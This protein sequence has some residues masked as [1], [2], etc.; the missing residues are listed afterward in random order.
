MEQVNTEQ[1]AAPQNHFFS[2]DV[3]SWRRQL[4][5]R[6]LRVMVIFGFLMAAGGSYFG[7]ISHTLW[8]IFAYF[9]VYFVIVLLAAWRRAPYWL[10]AVV[11]AAS[12]Y[13]IALVTFLMRGVG[14]SSRLYL[15]IMIFVAGIFGGWR[16]SVVAL[17]VSS[18][19]MVVLGWA[20]ASGHIVHYQDVV[21]T[22]AA[23]WVSLTVDLL[24][25][26]IFLMLV[27][28]YF[29]LRFAAVLT[30]RRK[31][32]WELEQQQTTLEEQVAERAADL[33]RRSAQLEAAA[34]VAREAAEIRDVEQ[35]LDMV[36]HLI[37]ARFGFYHTGIF[38]L[39]EAGE[40]A[41][42]RAVSSEG[43][44]RMLERGHRLRVG[45]TGIVG[46]VTGQGE[47]RVALDVGEDAVFF[48]NPD[49]PD[50]RSEMALPLRVRGKIIGAL[51]V[52]SVEAGEFTQEDV[53]V[54][55]TL[56]DQV[57]VAIEN[58]RL[59]TASQTALEAMQ[60][61]YGEVSRGAWQELLRA[62][63][64]LKA[65]YDPQG[66]MPPDDSWREEM[67][68]AFREGRPVFD[69]DGRLV[70]VPIKVRDQVIGILDAHKPAG[71]ED[72]SPGQIELLETL[73]DQL[74]AALE[75]ARLYQD[76]QLRAARERLAGRVAA[77]VRETLD[78]DVVLQTAVR[79]IGE[80]LGLHDV[81][82]Q[83]EDIGGE[84]GNV[85]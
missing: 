34:H 73:S 6:T 36:V 35:L 59:L 26:G 14:D 30:Q 60:R 21:S 12:L 13:T 79:E 83:F 7:Y 10:Q 66:I 76:T 64:G 8:A 33:A 25:M 16:E 69:A 58:A 71:E 5:N 45:E 4:I 55:Q 27:L 41:V 11:L 82:I 75:S 44:R 3:Q 80:A 29:M 38:L 52:Q 43:G 24:S 39:D 19:T 28:N 62:R 53:I 23:T 85:S 68:L 17:I 84:S 81:T 65:R 18:A 42:L 56:A 57:A 72:W 15:L 9:G 50:T 51:D 67:K 63:R 37:S 47:P 20:F 77:R 78:V 48:D 32:T 61:A 49:L 1:A 2:E 70:A 54:L 74:G 46:Y 40:Y 31:L 22:D